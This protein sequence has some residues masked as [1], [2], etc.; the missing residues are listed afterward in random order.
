M[1]P[2]V[3]PPIGISPFASSS[4]C[5][6]VLLWKYAQPSI[7]AYSPPLSPVQAKV[8]VWPKAKSSINE[9]FVSAVD[10]ACDL[11]QVTWF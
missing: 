2:T 6:A 11:G 3:L 10:L 8:L 5:S 4:V 1:L 9:R 7:A